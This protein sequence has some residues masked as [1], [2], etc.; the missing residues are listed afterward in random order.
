[1]Y[2]KELPEVLGVL[3]AFSAEL[4]SSWLLRTGI[5]VELVYVF[6]LS[7]SHVQSGRDFGQ[8]LDGFCKS[9]N[10]LPCV[11]RSA[12]CCMYTMG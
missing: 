8:D 7:S 6:F 10:I 9:K 3:L 1:M 5:A 11:S 2:R 4:H 12:A